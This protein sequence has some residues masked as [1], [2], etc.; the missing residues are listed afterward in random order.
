MTTVFPSDDESSG[1]DSLRDVTIVVRAVCALLLAGALTACDPPWDRS[2]I[3]V[4]HP[5]ALTRNI[6]VIGSMATGDAL[7]PFDQ[8]G[9]ELIAV[10]QP[11]ELSF[12][13]VPGLQVT[14]RVKSLNPLRSNIAQKTVY[15][16]VVSIPGNDPRL[17]A[18]QYVRAVVHQTLLPDAL[19]VP[20]GAVR[21]D[22]AQSY[23]T[24]AD[25][26]RRVFT[27]GLVG[28]EETEVKGGLSSGQ[29]VRLPR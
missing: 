5:G 9:S 14:G 25:G 26:N 21:T 20:N 7:I 24:D 16:A 8:P 4:V 22:G 29:Q 28:D 23:V 17:R 10:G 19:L 27:P 1:T 11:V 12:E 13:S 15:H 2:E 18:G 6:A 3:A